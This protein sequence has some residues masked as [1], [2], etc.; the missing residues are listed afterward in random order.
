MNTQTPI[1]NADRLLIRDALDDTVIVEAAAGT[2]K[3]TELV[4]RILNVLATG[5]ARIEQVVAVTFTEKAAGELKLR[6]RKELESLRQRSDAAAVH[7]R[8]TDAIGR[9]EE[10]HVSTIHGFCADLLRERPVEARIDPLFG[11]LA[12]AGAERIFGEAFHA[13]LHGQLEDP[14]EGVR[15]ALRRSVW[16]RDGRDRDDG[17]VE[18]LRRAAREL[19]EWRDFTGPWRRDPFDRDG[20]L[21][22]VIARVH[23]VASICSTAAS[24]HDPLY[25]DL[26]PVREVSHHIEIAARL[27]APDRDGWEARVIDLAQDRNVRRARRGRE[28]TYGPG[29]PRETVW[30]A[31]ETLMTELDRFQRAADCDLAALL[32]EELQGM[33]S[34]Y[35]RLKQR[36]GTL[37]FVDLLL[38]ARDLLVEHARVRQAFQSRFTHIFVDEFQDTDPLQAEILLLLA[39]DTAAERDW[40]RVT[41]IPGKLFIVGDPKQAIYRFRRADVETYREVCE[42]LEARGARRAFL[43]TSFRATPTIQRAVNAAFAPL[44]TG[45]RATV[46]AQYVALSSYRQENVGQPAVIALPVPEPYGQ[47]RM[48]GYAIEKSLPAG[49]GAFVHW[50]LRESGWT[51]TERTTPDDAPQLMRV[52]ARH[53][54][55]LFRRFLHFGEDVTRAY[56]EA[57]ESRG[58]PH[59]LVGGKSFHDREEV[60]TL[61]AALSAIEWP[62]DE[63]SVFATIRGALFAFDDETLLDYWHRYR[64]FH[65]FRV[66]AEVVPELGP[67]ADAL[68]LLRGLHSGRNHRPVADTVTRLLNATRAHVGFVLRQAGEQALANVL[69]VAELARRY[70]MSG[71]ISFRGFVEEL[72]E[73]A[74]GGQAAEAPILE[75]GSD[76]VRL[77]TV[78]KA[79]GLEFPVVVLADMTAKLRSERADRLIDRARHACYLRLG[80]WTPSELA[81]NEPLE[82]ARDEAEGVRVAYV[83]ATRARDLLVVPAVGDAVW[84]G[85]WTGPMNDAIYPVANARQAAAAAPGCPP[86]KKDSVWKRPDNDPASADTV[87]PGLHSCPGQGSDGAY[88]V[89]WWDPWA[90]NLDVE[91]SIGIR[92]ESLIMK[93]VPAS[94]VSE[95]LREYEKWRTLREQAIARGSTPSLLVRTATEWAASEGGPEVSADVLQR[96]LVLDARGP[97]RPGGMRF[98]ELVHA[99][100]A[101][102]PLQ[103]DRAAIDALAETQGRILAAP[104]DERAAAGDTVERILAHEVVARARHAD[105]RGACR[106]ETPVTLTLPDGALIEGIVDLAFEEDGAWTVV[107]YKTD[108]EMAAAGEDRY[109]RQVVFYASA[110]AAA[111]GQPAAGVLVRV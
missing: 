99:I 42:L 68:R 8:L 103:A 19:A 47:R 48:A 26:T 97:E 31:Y 92:R 21:G 56:V 73:Q 87:R 37:D 44:M 57:L 11:V 84:D 33:V 40:R 13:W 107:D 111:T 60:E 70:E 105:Q 4:R 17:P 12:E 27:D 28:R 55:I 75:E 81:L 83:A 36:A 86:F 41:P 78:H 89:T 29:V 1:D 108:R 50:L 5:R 109:R 2:G 102:V 51:V 24:T 30:T 82:I 43:Q 18:R 74:D 100:L 38:R 71:G 62:D 10:A 88:S 72:R 53:V 104:P 106:R 80:R 9:L 66:P 85:G 3:T 93:D 65:P 54:C 7:E 94:V 96:V 25:L 69:H 20:E 98:G 64:S 76:G 61:R 39:A 6:I 45:D 101:A 49:I 58:V 63:L 16:S 46:Q 23:E 34:E 79:K 91:L 59:L 32:H 14:P 52:E 22:R 110:I 95:G 35:E 15:R 67:V 77:M 90:L